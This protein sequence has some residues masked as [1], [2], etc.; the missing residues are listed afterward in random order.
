MP[1]QTWKGPWGGMDMR[2]G[3]AAPNSYFLGLNIDTSNGQLQA[4][5]GLAIMQE[6]APAYGRIHV[7]EHP[8]GSKK[9]IV[10]GGDATA[11][12]FAV[13]DADTYVAEGASQ[14][15]TTA[16]GEPGRD[17]MKC[18]FVDTVL[19]DALNNP[20]FVTLITTE[21]GSYVYDPKTD[22]ANV[23]RVVVSTD[24]RQVN[25]GNVYYA[26]APMQAPIAC[27]YNLQTYYAGFRPGQYLGIDGDI[28]A[29]VDGR[30]KMPPESYIGGD[31]S[32]IGLY[33]H[34]FMW[35]DEADPCGVAATNF[36]IV[37]PNERITGLHATSQALLV[38]TD[39]GIWVQ[40]DAASGIRKV[41]NGVGCIAHESIVTVGGVTYFAGIDGIYAFGG[42]GAPEATKISAQLDALWGE[43]GAIA[44]QLPEAMRAYLPKWG[45]P[46]SVDPRYTPFMVGRHYAKPNQIWWSLP[47]LGVWKARAMGLTLVYDVKGNSWNI[48]FRTPEYHATW[49]VSGSY[50]TVMTDAVQ[51]DGRLITTT[52]YGYL[53]EVGRSVTY[54]GS[55]AGPF[56]IELATSIPTY[57]CSHRFPDTDTDN[58]ELTG[59]WFRMKSERTGEC[60][61][62]GYP[63]VGS[64]AVPAPTPMWFVDGAEAAFD[65][66]NGSRTLVSTYDQRSTRTGALQN[67]PYGIVSGSFLG[68]Y[69]ILG[70]SKLAPT[71]WFSS[72]APC[73]IKS[74]SFRV[75][76]VDDG[77]L[78][79]RGPVAQFSSINLEIANTGTPRR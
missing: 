76:F 64:G 13:F 29:A 23:R 79:A 8:D 24:S 9:L 49:G 60:V 53:Q 16:F 78:T 68:S 36:N 57:W 66:E 51:V 71:D 2:E 58:L 45:F 26:A 4:R 7:V 72:R 56:E 25:S 59:L 34:V 10:L 62:S 74:K 5:P 47:V 12:E 67:H 75:G 33:P 52:A 40:Q 6:G 63:T 21:Y 69:F 18:S 50:L 32:W 38:F 31:R 44:S 42:L 22:A 15:L 61:T 48:Y 77:L 30:W 28:P 1:M 70:T 73:S 46:W 3:K 27:D 41:V 54:D 19:A 14:N 37:D 11:I 20:V 17:G 65:F 35:S 43:N 39:K 55:P